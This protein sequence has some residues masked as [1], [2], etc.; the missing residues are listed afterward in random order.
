MLTDEDVREICM[1]LK[2][3]KH[4]IMNKV[5]NYGEENGTKFYIIVLGVC[6][7]KI[8]NYKDIE[9][10]NGKYHEFQRLLSWKSE[11]MDPLID[12]AKKERE[13]LID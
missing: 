6:V 12:S 2:L 9:D 8:P 1:H 10:W 13:E 7:V 3:E 4:C 11:F 5:I